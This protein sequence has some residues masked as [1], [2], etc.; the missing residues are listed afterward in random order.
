MLNYTELFDYFKSERV[1]MVG[2][3]E[4]LTLEE[5]TRNR[6]LSF[7]SIKDTFLHTIWVENSW[8]HYAYRGKQNPSFRP[9]GYPDLESTK[10]FIAEV[11]EKTFT[12]F[13][14]L[15]PDDL[16]KMVTRIQSDGKEATYP[17]EIV[18]YHIPIEVIHHYGEIFAE[19]WKMNLDAPYLSY[20]RYYASK[21][22][23]S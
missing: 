21:P 3:L 13:N 4:K 11:D 6:E 2:A 15:K 18:L 23:R 19:F 16:K 8:L 1:K 14:E 22:S 7:Y 9:E 20:A 12:L 5:F 10:N 17:L